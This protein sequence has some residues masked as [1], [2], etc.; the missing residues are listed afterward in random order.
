MK[1]AGWIVLSIGVL[2]L[3]GGRNPFGPLF[4]IALGIFLLHRASQKEK[5]KKD[6]EDWNNGKSEES[7]WTKKS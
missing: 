4:W 3:I 7:S 6:K 2:S 5:E 1:I